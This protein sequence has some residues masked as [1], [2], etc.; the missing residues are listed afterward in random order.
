MILDS[1][2]L[3]KKRNMVR[4]CEKHNKRISRCTECGTASD[5]C[6]HEIL[7]FNCRVCI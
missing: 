2:N 7:R 1:T 5:I 4:K 3:Q 6:P